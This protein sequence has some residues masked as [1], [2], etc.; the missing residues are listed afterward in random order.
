MNKIFGAVGRAYYLLASL[1]SISFLMITLFNEFS[2]AN[3][4]FSLSIVPMA[5]LLHR[6]GYWV[7]F[8]K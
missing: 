7:I 5:I 1:L 8:G 3:L 2:I 4:V 6:V